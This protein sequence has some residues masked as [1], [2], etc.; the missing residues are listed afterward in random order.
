[1]CKTVIVIL[2]LFAASPA[3]AC[4]FGGPCGDQSPYDRLFQHDSDSD[5]NLGWSNEGDVPPS[6]S[7]GSRDSGFSYRAPS[8]GS[9]HSDDDDE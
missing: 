1:M 3:P 5:S 2:A 7:G 9:H 4:T 8:Y 6:Y